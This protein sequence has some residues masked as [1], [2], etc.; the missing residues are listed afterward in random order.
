MTK[1]EFAMVV[2]NV[3]T[4]VEHG[5]EPEMVVED[6]AGKEYE[7]IAYEE[8]IEFYDSENTCHRLQNIEEIL[9]FVPMEEI[10]YV[11]DDLGWDYS[12]DIL[13]NPMLLLGMMKR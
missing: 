13:E 9:Q 10:A 6:K 12:Q 8:W 2:G 11:E 1:E 4:M 3:T 5:F 7:V